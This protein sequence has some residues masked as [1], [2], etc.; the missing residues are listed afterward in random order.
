MARN[1][2][3][4]RPTPK[5]GKRIIE[6]TLHVNGF[7]TLGR[8]TLT[9][10][11]SCDIYPTRFMWREEAL[12]K[13]KVLITRP[14]PAPAVERVKSECEVTLNSEDRRLSPAEMH[15]ACREVE[16]LLS[17]GV[18]ITADI[19]DHAPHLRVV[20]AVAVGYDNIDIAACTKRRIL[21][22]NTPGVVTEATADL[23][24]ALLMA[25]ARRLVEADRYVRDGHWKYWQWG[26]MWGSNPSGKT[27]G[28]YGF[29]RI[30]QAVARRARG[31][32]MRILYH[33]I[34]RP[35]P[36]QE[37]A[38]GAQYVDRETLLR[39]SDFLSLHIPLSPSTHR[40]IGAAEFGLMKSSAFLINTSRGKVVEEAALVDALR[41]KRIAGA[42]LDVFEFEPQID[43]VLLSLPNVVVSP[44][45]GTATRETRLAM[46]ML[47]AENLLAALAGQ[48]PTHLVNPEVCS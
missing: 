1:P 7:D 24:F 5:E 19:I 27:L 29:G 15:E 13:P 3:Y 16:G 45:M 41:S 22:T 4:P 20:S 11:L 47:A 14:L 33:S 17:S 25:V 2:C 6:P 38:L 10:P 12:R 21:V 26:N 23:C 9:L 44:H 36:E 42:G 31:F 30:G 18:P 35:T 32:S 46:A 39:E 37:H 48:R 34:D 40:L 28:I 8:P 43:P